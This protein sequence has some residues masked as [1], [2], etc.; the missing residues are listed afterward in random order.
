MKKLKFK[1]QMA[2]FFKKIYRS[3][4]I[5][6]LTALITYLLKMVCFIGIS[7]FIPKYTFLASKIYPASQELVIRELIKGLDLCQQ[8]QIKI[9]FEQ[10]ILQFRRIALSRDAFLKEQLKL[11]DLQNLCQNMQEKLCSLSNY[12]ASEHHK[13]KSAID[14]LEVCLKVFPESWLSSNIYYIIFVLLFVA[15][16]IVL[17]L[18][19]I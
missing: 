11:K 13:L 9:T 16:N 5:I 19:K 10:L 1:L 18:K 6:F 2:P 8:I 17:R 7:A 4:I 15:I 12:D 3:G 14:A